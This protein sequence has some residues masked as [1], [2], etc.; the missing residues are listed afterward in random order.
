MSKGR[1][2]IEGPAP[3]AR[4][5]QEL[6]DLTGIKW[7]R[8]GPDVLPAWVADMDL[9]PPDFAVEAVT[10]LAA[11]GDFGYNRTA[12]DALPEAFAAWQTRH[13]D[14]EPEVDRLT[15]FND[16]LHAIEV[17]LWLH[18]KPGDGIVLLTPIYPPFLK[19]VHST[20]RRLI[21]VPLDPDGWRLDPDRLAAAI[22]SDTRAVLLCS[23]HNPTG[24]VF[25]QAEREAIAEVVARH[26]LLLI[27]DEVWGDLTHPGHRHR[28]M[29]TVG[30]LADRTVTISSAS[31][32]F[33]LAGLRSA[34]AH[35]G[36]TDLRRT[37]EGLPS[38]LLGAVSS[39]GAEA[40]VACWTAGDDWLAATCG[41]LTD[42]RDQL[43]ARLAADAPEI[44]YRQ[45][46]ATYLN[47]MAFPE[48]LGPEPADRLKAGGL[49][50][51]PG[52]D[53]GPGGAGFARLNVATSPELLDRIVDRLVAC[54]A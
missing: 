45:P 50:L 49:S 14:W 2:H 12:A 33:N 16:V 18:T 21:D 53:F 41:Y 22:D 31:K 25:D 32:A 17:S 9:A 1:G 15:L 40:A 36:H 34:V 44:G 39:P 6:R 47:W 35:I 38:H 8:D 30:D 54:L 20:G 29:A 19:T 24:R 26:D 13:H 4:T 37:I 46:E 42:R 23:P 11:R 27:S 48:R 28:P 51:S 5:E 52:T 43:A 3:R 10:A 7:S